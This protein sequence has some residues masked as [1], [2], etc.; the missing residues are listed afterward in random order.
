MAEQMTRKGL[1]EPILEQGIQNT[2]F[3]NGRLLTAGDLRTEQGANRRQHWQLGQA[4]GAG[5]VHGLEVS[6]VTAG[7]GGGPPVV[8]LTSGLA[9]NRMGQAVALLIDLPEVMLARQSQPLPSEAGLFA[10]CEPPK[11]GTTP[12]GMGVYIL[13]ITPA[14]G[15]REKVPMRGLGEKGKV[16]GCGSRY[17]VEGVKFR[18]EELKVNSLTGI[19]QTTRDTLN[20]LMTKSDSA[21]LSQLRNLLAYVCFGSEEQSDFSRDPLRRVG[22]RSPYTTYGAIDA[23]RSTG[24]L[25][26][27]DV[28]LALLHWTTSG[29]QF[30]DMWA[31]RRRLVQPLVGDPWPLLVGQRRLAEAEA[32]F[33]QF[34]EQIHDMVLRDS[35]LSSVTALSRFRYLPPAGYLPLGPGGFSSNVFF[36]GLD[37]EQV[38]VDTAFLRLLVHQSW[39]LEPIDLSAP[40]P[41]RLYQAPQSVD[42]LL[43]VR[44]ERRPVEPSGPPPPPEPGTTPST[45][46]INVD[47]DVSE[48]LKSSAAVRT[49]L[50]VGEKLREEVNIKVWAEDDLGNE[51]QA[52]FVPSGSRIGF[53]GEKEFEFDR[54]IARFTIAALPAGAYTVRVRMKGFKEASRRKTLNAGQTLRVVFK[55]VPETK[56]PGSGVEQPKGTGKGDWIDLKWYDKIAV[57]ERYFKWPWPPEE[58]LGFDPVVDPPP[59]AVQEWM[60]DWADW[61][62]LQQPAAPIDPGNIRIHIDRSH[63]PDV[64]PQDPY[65]YLVFGDGGAYVPV[66]LTPTDRTLDRPVAVTKGGLA[67]VDRDVEDQLKSVGLTD[68]D[69]LGASWKGLVADAMGVSAA[70]ASSVIAEA[71]GKVDELQGSLRIFSGVEKTLEDGLKAAGINDAVGLANADAQT[72]VGRLGEQGVT[73]AF[74]QRLVDEARQAVPASAWSLSAGKLGLK[75]QEIAALNAL[76]ITTQGVL[77]T[78][79]ADPTERTRIS[80]SIGVS[81]GALGTLVDS[82][83]IARFATEFKGTRITGAPTTSVVGVNRDSAKALAGIG[84]GTVRDLA[85]ANAN[86]I[87]S[88]F[89]GDLAKATEVINAAKTKANIGR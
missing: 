56:K 15:F 85:L 42:Y 8:S 25:T 57:F 18:L 34:Q 86:V 9:L 54:G 59:F 6:L 41:L 10:E 2:H 29:V 76:G 81:A 62:R 69:V 60:K 51:Y 43:F 3:F 32:M 47:V 53:V 71:R 7:S 24:N 16:E 77:K 30:I 83:D 14:S 49:L 39:F 68:L 1:G 75:D 65:A 63:T 45:G 20:D 78:R 11:N 5:V 82:I 66:V 67:G 37:V 33:L 38:Q 28:P 50:P 73:L 4:I 21:S 84:V 44:R 17:A 88:A 40:A 12:T 70:T 74:A 22:G 23:L 19:S 13:V 55:L 79:A 52:R 87:A 46:R 80:S 26:D 89:G 31:V 35:T 61:F 72:L 58:V 64:T 36:Q 27:C 48:A